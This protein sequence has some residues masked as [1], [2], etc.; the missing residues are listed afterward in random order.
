MDI[1]FNSVKELY[2]RLKPALTT[3]VTE[4]KRNELDYIKTEDV[5]NYLKD[6]K[7]SKANNLLLYQMVDDILNLNN[8]E[9][10]EYVKGEIRKKVIQPNLENMK[11]DDDY[12]KKEE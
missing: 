6:S 9:I 4:L 5:W 1:E 3:K 2:E 8:N 12:D 11:W 7:W 10:D